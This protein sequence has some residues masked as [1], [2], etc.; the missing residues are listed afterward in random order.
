MPKMTEGENDVKSNPD[1]KS[2]LIVTPAFFPRKGGIETVC[3]LLA[4]AFS[5]NGWRITVV[6]SEHIA[7][8]L[9][10]YLDYKVIR[11]PTSS[12]L[13]RCYKSHQLVFI[14]QGMASLGWPSLLF[15]NRCL[16]SYH[17]FVSWKSRPSIISFLL[18]RIMRKVIVSGA[19]SRHLAK[20]LGN[21]I[22]FLPNPYDD[23]VFKLSNKTT[24]V[25][26]VC[27]VGRMIECKGVCVLLDALAVLDKQGIKLRCVLIGDGSDKRDFML[28]TTTL[29]LQNSVEWKPTMNSVEIADILNHSKVL[30]VPSTWEEP[31]GIVA[32]EGIASG[33]RVIASRVAG[34]PE[35]V[36]RCGVL[37]APGDSQTLAAAISKEIRDWLP[38][39]ELNENCKKH[40]R[41]HNPCKVAEAFL[42]AATGTKACD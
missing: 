5:K 7:P 38:V 22:C 18:G 8:G 11:N 39:V 23:E 24:R 25:F 4:R 20:T 3:L 30:C 41:E 13:F 9:S 6:T 32:L 1:D 33:C 2:L 21:N 17:I 42:M 31:F 27:Y 37:V 10:C 16:L 36:G 15:R 14:M 35:A 12:Q 29:G 26:D 34:L 19:C 28:R 40:L